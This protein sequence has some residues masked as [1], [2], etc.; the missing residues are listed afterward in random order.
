MA[1]PKPTQAEIDAVAK[2]L[3]ATVPTPPRTL[4]PAFGRIIPGQIV[5]LGTVITD[6]GGNLRRNEAVMRMPLLD[7]G[8]L[9]KAAILQQV[10]ADRRRAED[11]QRANGVKMRTYPDGCTCPKLPADGTAQ[12]Y[13][14]AC[15]IQGHQRLALAARH[16]KC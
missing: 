3:L 10:A 6:S 2:A 12:T 14:L 1:R 11:R 15:P 5:K 7:W 4:G 16:R 9:F 13:D 8:P